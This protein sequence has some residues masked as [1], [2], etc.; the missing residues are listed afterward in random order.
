MLQATPLDEKR[1]GT[2]A[3]LL[4]SLGKERRLLSGLCQKN[5]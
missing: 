1:G 3:A 2:A 4:K 5:R